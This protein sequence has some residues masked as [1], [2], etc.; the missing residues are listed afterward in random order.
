MKINN[1]NVKKLVSAGILPLVE[2]SS[3]KAVSYDMIKTLFSAG[4]IYPDGLKKDNLL[5]APGT[6]SHINTHN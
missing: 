5:T 3:T 2:K 4:L 6:L 1:K